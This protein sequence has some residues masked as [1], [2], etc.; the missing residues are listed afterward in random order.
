MCAHTADIVLLVKDCCYVNSLVDSHSHW[1]VTLLLWALKKLNI[2]LTVRSAILI[3]AVLVI[4]CRRDISITIYYHYTRATHALGKVD[5]HMDRCKKGITICFSNDNIIIAN[6]AYKLN[7][8]NNN[9]ISGKKN[10][11]SYLSMVNRWHGDY[12]REAY[13]EDKAMFMP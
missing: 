4:L 1:P 2:A 7:I 3:I 10:T 6:I 8:S 11:V 12:F 5:W 9:T 13:N